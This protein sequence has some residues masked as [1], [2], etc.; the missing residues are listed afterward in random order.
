MHGFIVAAGPGSRMGFFTESRPKCLLPI[1]GTT[2]LEN[3]ISNFRRVGC[4]EIT[5]IVGHKA[6]MIRFP[7]VNYVLN[8]AY[9]DNNILHS[10]MKARDHLVG[11]VV[12]SYGDIWIEPWVLD[13]LLEAVGDIS[14]AV[15]QDWLPYYEGRTKHGVSEAENVFFDDSRRVVKIGKHLEPR[16]AAQLTCGE[17]IGLWRMTEVGTSWFTREFALLDDRL[18]SNEPFQQATQWR[19]AYITDIV[20]QLVDHGRRVNCAVIERGWAELDTEQDVQRLSVI[21][22]QQRLQTIVETGSLP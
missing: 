4:T 16:L 17:F 20:Q 7:D 3:V 22:K 8:S 18:S 1:A 6:E 5:V 14:L 9:R 15:D 2:L 13:K 19:R 21:A 12:V 11:P 10:L